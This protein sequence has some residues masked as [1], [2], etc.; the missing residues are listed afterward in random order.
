MVVIPTSSYLLKKSKKGR[1]K[2]QFRAD[3][4]L[5]SACWKAGRKYPVSGHNKEMNVFVSLVL[6]MSQ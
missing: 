1:E 5:S 6:N 2:L 3:F 4:P